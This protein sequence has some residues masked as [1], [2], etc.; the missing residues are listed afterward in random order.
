MLEGGAF[1]RWLSPKS[2]AL[3][4]GIVA[5][6]KDPKSP[7]AHYTMWGYSVKTQSMNQEAGP[8]QTPK[9]LG[10]L[11]LNFSAFRT[12]WKKFL[13]LISLLVSDF[14]QQP[15]LNKKALEPA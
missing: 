9:L 5:P 14:L 6:I 2:R 10:T 3:L 15:K 7:T 13:L 8:Q 1:G 12:V 11:I 4:Y